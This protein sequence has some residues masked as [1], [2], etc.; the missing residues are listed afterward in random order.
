MNQAE[1]LHISNTKLAGYKSI[2]NISTTLNSGLNIIIGKNAVGKTNFLT[3]L[4]NSL[5]FN[6]T[7]SNNFDAYFFINYNKVDYSF[8]FNKKTVLQNSNSINTKFDILGMKAIKPTFKAR[9]T[10]DDKKNNIIGDFSSSDESQCGELFKKQLAHDNIQL[11][12]TLIRHGLPIN[13]SII[14]SP[15]NIELWNRFISDDF[16]NL[17]TSD[18]QSI[19]FKTL[20]LA[21]VTSDVISNKYFKRKRSAK[22]IEKFILTSKQNYKKEIFENLE[23]LHELKD[24]LKQYSPIED[25]RF[26]D[27]F[28]IDLDFENQKVSL[29][30]FFLEFL[31]D[32]KWFSFEDLSDGTKRIFYIISEIF[33]L[34][35][36]NQISAIN[37][38]HG[39]ITN[40]LNVIFIEEPELGIHPHQLFRLMQFLKEK[41]RLNQIVITTHSPLSLDILE[42]NELDSIF[43]AE[44][45]N[46][47][48]QLKKLSKDKIEKAQLYMDDLNLSDF[49]L[50]SDLED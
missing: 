5:I 6:F 8:S 4:H 37:R 44:K 12:S 26:N 40:V 43:I 24:L 29:R 32:K 1:K 20:L 14:D 27:S 18:N 25:F 28:T 47:Q 35:R 46:G 22:S 45:I 38:E 13:Y 16:I 17:Y 21:T 39:I 33:I 11:N 42:K 34:D 10:V 3:F 50:N 31:I 36:N 30:N 15:L 19:F 2:D 48:T 9:L 49:W 41:S 7:H 23:Y